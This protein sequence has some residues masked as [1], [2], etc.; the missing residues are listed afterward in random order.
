[1]DRRERGR[2][3]GTRVK[4]KEGSDK[5]REDRSGGEANAAISNGLDDV[6]VREERT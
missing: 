5:G 4:G 2:R 6:S 3:A 1:M